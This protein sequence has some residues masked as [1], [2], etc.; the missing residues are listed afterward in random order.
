MEEVDI[1][2][3]YSVSIHDLTQSS[4]HTAAWPNTRVRLGQRMITNEAPREEKSLFSNINET[5][6]QFLDILKSVILLI[7]F[8]FFFVILNYY[9]ILCTQ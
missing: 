1:H 9:K 3:I 5:A 6:V 7:F 8:S 4:M 2:G